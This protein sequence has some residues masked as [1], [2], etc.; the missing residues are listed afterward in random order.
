M[1]GPEMTNKKSIVSA[2][3]QVLNKGKEHNWNFSYTM[4]SINSQVTK[5]K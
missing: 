4:Y 5:K 3:K 2:A 1:H